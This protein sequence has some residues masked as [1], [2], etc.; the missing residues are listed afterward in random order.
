MD[1]ALEGVFDAPSTAQSSGAASSGQATST[2]TAELGVRDGRTFN[3][4][5]PSTA[6]LRNR[7]VAALATSVSPTVERGRSR[8]LERP[9]RFTS[10]KV[11]TTHDTTLKSKS[12]NRLPKASLS[13]RGKQEVTADERLDI[14][15]A[16]AKKKAGRAKTPERTV[17]AIEDRPQFLASP[18]PLMQPYEANLEQVAPI[19]MT[20]G[21][22]GQA[23][24]T[25]IASTVGVHNFNLRFLI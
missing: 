15:I 4:D 24:E 19:Q 9:N 5:S 10:M 13:P 7:M 18:D 20:T 11:T 14:A 12:K 23:M 1:P 16:E 3:D 6:L 8:R 22:D 21:V 2:N 25:S 17:V